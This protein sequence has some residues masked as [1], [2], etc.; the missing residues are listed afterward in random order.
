MEWFQS[1]PGMIA[2]KLLKA[3]MDHATTSRV[4]KRASEP[5][6]FAF[7]TLR[8]IRVSIVAELDAINGNID[9]SSKCCCASAPS[10]YIL[11]SR[12]H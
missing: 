5:V 1:F 2:P 8:S 11:R 9:T 10:P 7:L 4:L 12:H 3:V 6:L